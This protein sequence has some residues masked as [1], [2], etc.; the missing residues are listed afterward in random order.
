MQRCGMSKRLKT[1]S[2]TYGGSRCHR[3]VR[4]RFVNIL[5]QNYLFG[6]SQVGGVTVALW[7]TYWT[8]YYRVVGSIS[9]PSMVHFWISG[10]FNLLSTNYWFIHKTFKFWPISG[11]PELL[12]FSPA[13]A[14][15]EATREER[16]QVRTAIRFKK[17]PFMVHCDF[18][19]G[20]QNK[21]FQSILLVGREGITKKEYSVYATVFSWQ[22]WTTP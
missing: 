4:E 7:L 13:Y 1:V 18:D 19:K 2:R 14:G 11:C 16:G 10:S 15:R 5:F 12:S 8:R 17:M 20:S 21:H 9:T 6:V 22:F 3:C